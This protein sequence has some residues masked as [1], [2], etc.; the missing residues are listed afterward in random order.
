MTEEHEPLKPTRRGVLI[1]AVAAT[2]GAVAGV[3]AGAAIVNPQQPNAAPPEPEGAAPAAGAPVNPTGPNQ[4]GIARP[5][6]PQ[7][8][9]RIRV[10]DLGDG[11]GSDPSDWLGALGERILELAAGVPGVLPDGPGDLTVTVGLGPRLVAAIDPTLPGAEELPSFAGDDAIP[12]SARGGD[13][14]L[15]VYSSDPGVLRPVLEDLVG[16]VPAASTR[17]EQAAFRA[18]GEGT[19]TRNPLGF[20]DGVIVPKGDAEL[21]E[22]VWIGSGPAAGG[23]ICV[24]RRLRLDSDRFHALPV[25]GQEQ[26]FGR[27]RDTGAPLS[28]GEPDAQV[29]LAARTPEGDPVIPAN[30]HARAAHPSFTGSALM[31]RRG[32]AFDNGDGDAGLMFICFQHDLRTFVVTQQ[33]LD[34]VDALRQF[35]HATASATFL[36]LPGFDRDRPLGSSLTAT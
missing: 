9:G 31:L 10:L 16:L 18:P 8:F 20:H 19:K 24:I 28:G 23:A 17:W 36:I 2:V 27:R 13:L 29:D 32:Y 21:D 3:S 30:A 5:H 12:A 25:S 6:T 33:R 4:A 14:L 35:T 11:D 7:R 22:N 26:I 34:E 1:G 15:A